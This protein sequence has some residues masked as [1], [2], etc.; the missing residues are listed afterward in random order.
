MTFS[1]G[2]K[3]EVMTIWDAGRGREETL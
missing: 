2:S 1:I 3:G